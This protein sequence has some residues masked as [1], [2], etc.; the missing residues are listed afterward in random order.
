LRRISAGSA[1]S[2]FVTVNEESAMAAAAAPDDD[3]AAGRRRSA[4]HDISVA[5]KDVF[6]IR[7]APTVG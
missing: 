1:L 5:I 4:L 3:L 7:E 6:A 2:A